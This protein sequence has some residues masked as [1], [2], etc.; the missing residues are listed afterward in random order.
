MTDEASETRIAHYR[1]R[2]IEAR[3]MAALAADP[4]ARAILLD[5]ANSW[6]RLAGLEKKMSQPRQTDPLPIFEPPSSHDP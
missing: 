5:V 6:D 1:Q 2:A 3:S 4:S